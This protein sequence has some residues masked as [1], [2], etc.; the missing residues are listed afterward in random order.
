MGKH[1]RTTNDAM[2]LTLVHSVYKIKKVKTDT[3]VVEKSVFV[4]ELRIKKWFKKDSITSVQEYVTGKNTISK[5]RCVVFDKYSAQMYAVE[6][7][8]DQII[9][10]T[11]G[12]HNQIGF[13]KWH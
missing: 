8:S 5:T 10:L 12:L 11:S 2:E 13:N 1:I 3:E 6:H 7:T 9:H 4:K